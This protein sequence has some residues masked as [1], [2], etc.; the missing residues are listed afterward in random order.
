MFQGP[1]IKLL[2]LWSKHPEIDA[3]QFCE[4]L[5]TG[6][7]HSYFLTNDYKSKTIFITK[8]TGTGDMTQQDMTVSLTERDQQRLVQIWNDH[9]KINTQK[10]SSL[11]ELVSL[12]NP[13]QALRDLQPYM[14]VLPFFE[15]K[16]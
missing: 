4:L 14:C 7:F 2:D 13:T 16:A 10:Q 6:T 9:T 5:R 1:Q 15:K 11:C 12:H 3:L 8:G